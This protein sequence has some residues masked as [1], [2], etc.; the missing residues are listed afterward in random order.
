[1]SKKRMTRNRGKN[2][3]PKPQKKPMQAYSIDPVE[4][5]KAKRKLKRMTSGLTTKIE[6]LKKQKA[7]A[8]GEALL[9]ATVRTIH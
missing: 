3:K 9:D 2:K 8:E 6:F 7:H 1:M 5:K 4:R